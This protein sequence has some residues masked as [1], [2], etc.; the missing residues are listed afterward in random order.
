MFGRLKDWR[1]MPTR[2]D[3]CPRVFLSA[4]ALAA[5]VLFRL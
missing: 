1:R 5:T 3:R 2:D 4:V